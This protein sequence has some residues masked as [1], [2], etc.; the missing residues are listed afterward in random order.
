MFIS[1]PFHHG[2]VSPSTKGRIR[3]ERELC[4]EHDTLK[5]SDAFAAKEAFS[6][7]LQQGIRLRMLVWVAA[8]SVSVDYNQSPY[9]AKLEGFQGHENP[10]WRGL[11]ENYIIWIQRSKA[12]TL[13]D[14]LGQRTDL[15]DSILP[16][17]DAYTKAI[18]I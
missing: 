11:L 15:P 13:A 8:R 14:L 2:H 5:A 4:L 10:E 16:T 12:R 1:T 17:I 7:I 9:K 3:F 6:V 18:K